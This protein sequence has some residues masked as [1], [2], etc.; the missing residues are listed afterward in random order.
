[1]IRRRPRPRLGGLARA[2]V[3]VSV[4]IGCASTATSDTASPAAVG[5]LVPVLSSPG[6]SGQGSGEASPSTEVPEGP[7]SVGFG[8][9]RIRVDDRVEHLVWIADDDAR[10]ARGLM[11]ITDRGLEGRVGMAFLFPGDTTGGF[12]MR[13]TRLPLDIVFVDAQGSVVAIESMVPCA[14]R[15]PTCPITSPGARYRWALEVPSGT[16]LTLGVDEGSRL[17]V[18]V[19]A[20]S[21]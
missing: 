17:E 13:N 2:G 20:G 7:L 14:D 18:T 8:R 12:W 11:E 6:S 19:D 5:D 1:M 16:L 3:A 9:G 10:R 4:L 21:S 15:A